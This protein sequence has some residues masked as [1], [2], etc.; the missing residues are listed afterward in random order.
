MNVMHS[1]M[2]IFSQFSLWNYSTEKNFLSKDT[3]HKLKE[4]FKKGI[5]KE[6]VIYL[7]FDAVT[8]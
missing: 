4:I 3:F 6:K 8:V 1:S 7:F 2:G 5:R